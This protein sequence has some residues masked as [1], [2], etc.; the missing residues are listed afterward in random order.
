MNPKLPRIRQIILLPL[1]F[2]TAAIL[3]IYILALAEN[4]HGLEIT[5]LK[6]TLIIF[7]VITMVNII[8]VILANQKFCTLKKEAAEAVTLLSLYKNQCSLLERQLDKMRYTKH[9]TKN[10]IMLLNLYWQMNDYIKLEKYLKQFINERQELDQR[11]YCCNHLINA[12]LNDFA[13]R[14][15]KDGI[16]ISL[17]IQPIENALP[18]DDFD[19]FSLLSNI[20]AN[21]LEAS[22]RIKSQSD[23]RI[24]INI[25]FT[26]NNFIITAQN[27]IQHPIRTSGTQYLTSKNEADNHGI[28]LKIIK[29]IAKKYAGD[30]IIKHNDKAF[31]ISVLLHFSMKKTPPRV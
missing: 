23:R 16:E 13:E 30:A 3:T 25:N 1:F 31:T 21:A 29:R 4:M 15:D 12:A 20:F 2:I 11:I 22:C 27:S 9:E 7:H 8:F 6:R 14:A 24:N 26:E 18:V 28:G 10:Q 17:T 19:L 5:H